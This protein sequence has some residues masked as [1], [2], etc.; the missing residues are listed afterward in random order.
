L[1]GKADF[2]HLDLVRVRAFLAIVMVVN[3]RGPGLVPVA[4]FIKMFG[5]IELESIQ[6]GHSERVQGRLARHS[7][8]PPDGL[9]AAP[10]A[11]QA[12]FENVESRKELSLGKSINLLPER[13]VRLKQPLQTAEASV[14]RHVVKNKLA[15]KAASFPAMQNTA[16]QNSARTRRRA[17]IR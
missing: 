1:F 4:E 6:H 14:F 5:V 17:W 2:S 11:I 8:P 3:A 15:H 12:G 9:G 10:P 7:Q 13:Q 16:R